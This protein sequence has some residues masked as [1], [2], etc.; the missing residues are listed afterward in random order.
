MTR[1]TML[2]ERIGQ[3]MKHIV[4]VQLTV[5]DDGQTLSGKSVDHGE[6]TERPAIIRAIHDE[7]IGPDMIGPTGSETDTGSIIEP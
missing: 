2:N 1:W 3:T 4:R 6:Y 5:D 7:V